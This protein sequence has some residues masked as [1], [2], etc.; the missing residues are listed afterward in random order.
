MTDWLIIV[1]F[2]PVLLISIWAS[3]L[4]G[5]WLAYWVQ[6]WLTGEK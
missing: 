6:R 2:V 3:N 5:Q 1:A 4:I